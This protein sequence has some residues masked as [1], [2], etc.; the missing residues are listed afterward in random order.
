[1]YTEYTR[2]AM[3]GHGWVAGELPVRCERPRSWAIVMGVAGIAGEDIV[4]A[5]GRA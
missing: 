5:K 2:S 3:W 4:L 1:M